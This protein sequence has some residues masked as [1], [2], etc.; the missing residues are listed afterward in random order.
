MYAV[1][2]NN[3]TLLSLQACN[4]T[5]SGCN[6]VRKQSTAKFSSESLPA[7]GPAGHTGRAARPRSARKS[8][9]VYIYLL[10]MLFARPRDGGRHASRRRPPAAAGGRAQKASKKSDELTLH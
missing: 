6:V 8:R 10:F 1:T 7:A 2:N 5:F 3:S 9:A 4:L